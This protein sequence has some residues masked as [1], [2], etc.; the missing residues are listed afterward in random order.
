MSKS[1]RSK[2]SRSWDVVFIATC[3]PKR[4]IRIGN[5]QCFRLFEK[6]RPACQTP[7][8]PWGG[9]IRA[10]RAPKMAQNLHFYGVFLSCIKVKKWPRNRISRG[11]VANF[12]EPRVRRRSEK[13]ACLRCFLAFNQKKHAF[14]QGFWPLRA[15]P[16][17]QRE[18]KKQHFTCIFACFLHL[19]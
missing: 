14:L 13:P 10:P 6:K 5:L 2:F 11:Q 7:L 1:F 15:Q 3:T 4:G 18:R 12:L 8:Y 19:R 16:E 17:T 9:W